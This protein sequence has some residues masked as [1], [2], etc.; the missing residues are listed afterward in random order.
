MSAI[1]ET[2]VEDIRRKQELQQ[3]LQENPNLETTMML[4]AGKV[5]TLTIVNGVPVITEDEMPV[6]FNY[7]LPDVA[8]MH[9]T[10]VYRIY[11]LLRNVMVA[12]KED[13][14][15]AEA[16]SKSV[17]QT[18]LRP[19]DAV[20]DGVRIEPP[21]MPPALEIISSFS[22]GSTD[23]R[24]QADNHGMYRHLEI[25]QARYR[26]L[27]A[28]NPD[29]DPILIRTASENL[30]V[31]TVRGEIVVQ[32]SSV[33]GL[34]YVQVRDTP[35]CHL[36]QL[37]RNIQGLEEKLYGSSVNITVKKAA[38]KVTAAETLARQLEELECGRLAINIRSRKKVLYLSGEEKL[39]VY[40]GTKS[41]L[42]NGKIVDEPSTQEPTGFT[43]VEYGALPKPVIAVL[44]A[45]WAY[46]S[47][48]AAK[49]EV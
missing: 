13:K 28:K 39:I 20:E 22:S 35:Q 48:K 15:R 29:L 25:L 26:E 27:L 43:K 10:P 32:T 46:I 11:F 3:L 8:D 21:T 42:E 12:E 40:R 34:N 41:A 18:Q 6:A 30:Q 45:Y 37:A 23:L 33:A 7:D 36:L 5:V 9:G 2:E 31:S 19:V 1:I 14:A 47:P 16:A 17:I 49:Q 38:P 4:D 24:T 44:Q